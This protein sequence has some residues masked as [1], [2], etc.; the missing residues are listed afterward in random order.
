MRSRTAGVEAATVCG[1]AVGSG[2]WAAKIQK[3]PE[4]CCDADSQGDSQEV[5]GGRDVGC[6]GHQVHP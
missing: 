3:E 2:A 5:S 1:E 6:G 4:A